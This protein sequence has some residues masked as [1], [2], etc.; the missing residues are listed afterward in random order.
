MKY[1]FHENKNMHAR[2]VDS[3]PA[4]SEKPIKLGGIR[5]TLQLFLKK[6]LQHVSNETVFGSKTWCFRCGF[7]DAAC[8]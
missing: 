4:S 6:E 3:L 5:E 7:V 8:V 1:P 2:T